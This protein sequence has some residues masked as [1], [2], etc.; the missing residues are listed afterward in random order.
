VTGAY[1]HPP[2]QKLLFRRSFWNL[3][4]AV[5]CL[6][7]ADFHISRL[8]AQTSDPVTIREVIE[9]NRFSRG[10]DLSETKPGRH[11]R[12]GLLKGFST[13]APPSWRLLQWSSRFPLEPVN[14]TNTAHGGLLCSNAAK[15][16]IVG[17]EKSAERDLIL[18]ANTR[19]EYGPRARKLGDPWVHL[20]VEQDFE[21]PVPLH[22]LSAAKLHVEARLS[23]ARNLHEG[24]YSPGVHAAQ[25][26]I[27]FTV[28]NRNRQSA[29]HGDLVWFG[30]PIYDNRD[31]FPKEFK[32]QDFG[33]TAKFI[34]TPRGETY[35]TNSAHDGEWITIDKD[36]LPL[37]REALETA[38]ARGFLT[39]SKDI[40]DYYIGAMNMGWELPG[41]FDVEMQV[42]NLSLKVVEK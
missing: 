12:Y 10:F 36:L 7:G 39:G 37:M 1:H 40:S 33:G 31:R 28:Q 35:T 18:A 8:R 16:V 32:A 6:L 5:C 4:F 27:F 24:D 14:Q 26:Q 3:S 21:P 13:A 41:T 9:D 22:K 25:F 30:V 29:G 34:Y 20:L 23:R 42:R 19:V 11:V 17:V 15:A 38:W 2:N